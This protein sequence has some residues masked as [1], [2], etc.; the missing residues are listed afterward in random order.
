MPEPR[1]GTTPIRAERAGIRAARQT[2]TEQQARPQRRMP[3]GNSTATTQ[4]RRPAAMELP[5]RAAPIRPCKTIPMAPAA[6]MADSRAAPEKRAPQA[7]SMMAPP[8]TMPEVTRA[9]PKP[10]PTD[11]AVEADGAKAPPGSRPLATRDISRV[12]PATTRAPR[13]TIRPAFRPINRLPALTTLTPRP[14]RRNRTIVRAERAIMLPAPE[15]EPEPAETVLREPTGTAQPEPAAT[16]QRRRLWQP[17]GWSGGGSSRQPLSRLQLVGP[18]LCGERR[19]SLCHAVESQR[20]G[21]ESLLSASPLSARTKFSD[22]RATKLGQV[23]RSSWPVVERPIAAKRNA[24][25]DF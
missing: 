22:E 16:A 1:A 14:A 8:T 4:G 5:I 3:P 25:A 12:K 24:K 9:R 10:L 15:P 6:Q 20:L 2:L 18:V 13:G 19:R 17:D 23:G 7:A 21:R 11:K